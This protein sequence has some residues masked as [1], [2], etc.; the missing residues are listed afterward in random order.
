MLLEKSKSIAVK[1]IEQKERHT[2]SG[3]VPSNQVSLSTT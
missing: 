2:N 3:K 1:T